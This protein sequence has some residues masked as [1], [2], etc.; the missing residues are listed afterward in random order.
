VVLSF[1]Y[2]LVHRAFGALGLARRDAI[3][4]DAEILVLRHQV[5]VLRTKSAEPASPGRT[6]HWSPC[7]PASSHERPS[8]SSCVS[9]GNSQGGG[10]ETR[11]AHQFRG[12]DISVG[13]DYRQTLGP[14]ALPCDSRPAT[15]RVDRRNARSPA[16][17]GGQGNAMGK[18]SALFIGGTGTI[19][20]ACVTVAL[21]RGIDLTVLNRGRTTE[22]PLPRDVQTIDA[23]IR[24][25]AA[26]RAALRDRQFDA[27]VD[28]VAFSPD[29]VDIDVELFTGRTGQYVFVSSA[30][31]YH[32]PVPRLP[33]VESTL[34]HNPYWAYSRA[35]IACEERLLATFRDQGFPVTIVRPSH[36]YDRTSV[37]ILGGWTALERARRG[38]PV[39]V[40]GDGTSL[41]VLT[42][43]LDFA[44]AFVALLGLPQAV[45]ST[46]HITSDE[47]LTWNQI[48]TILVRAAGVDP[49]L[50]H[51]TSERIA[52]SEPEWGPG[53]LGDKSHSV[54]FDNSEIRRLVPGWV[55]TIPWVQGARE[56]VAWRDADPARQVIDGRTEATLD[57]LVA[58]AR[59]DV[60]RPPP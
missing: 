10:I 3:A 18:L 54:I 11:T 37:P 35:K 7:S 1:L 22:R 46:V 58:V 21:D 16:G 29:H 8:S 38:L 25:P 30:S 2:R 27:V 52:H 41:W 34:L 24:D 9:P 53:L 57:S 51:L 6:G 17:A 45:G 60:R 36:T 15:S 26:V 40:H 50:V 39:V 14:F 4:K 44:R 56:I 31:A 59:P 42:H 48:V 47:V 28:F 55:A 13:V 19:S 49:D 23:D 12:D 33:I 20:S 32:K 5:A 43:H